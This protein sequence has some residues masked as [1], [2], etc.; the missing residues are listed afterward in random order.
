MECPTLP[1][2]NILAAHSPAAPDSAEHIESTGTDWRL[3]RA[4]MVLVFA[5]WT[6][7]ALLAA[8][9]RI[10]DP[11]TPGLQF[12]LPTGPVALAFTESYLWALLTPA[13]FWLSS[14]F[15]IDRANRV[16]RILLLIGIGLLVAVGVDL[17]LDLFRLQL[18]DVPRW[19]RGNS[20][21]WLPITRL[22]FLNDLI[23]FFAI[24]SAGFA[25]DYFLRYRARQE[26][27][28]RLQAQ[29]AQLRAQLSE[30]RLTALQMQVNPHF[31]FN[32]L[33]AV[34]TLVERD[35]RCVRRMIAR[36]SELLR[37]TLDGAAAQEVPLRQELQFLERY[38]D[39]MQVRFQ[40]RMVVETEVD[41]S[42]MDALVPNLILQPV[43]ENAIKHGVSKM[44]AE[45]RIEIAARRSGD[46]LV[47]TVLDNGPGLT[48]EPRAEGGDGLGLANT[49]ARLEQL[50]GE[51]QRLT[52]EPA[53]DGRGAMAR[54]ELPFHE[55]PA[56]SAEPH[57]ATAR[58]ESHV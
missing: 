44:S 11:R 12:G 19:R 33:H 43:V 29:T 36:L 17:M 47:L 13:I 15:S 30:A 24:L 31:L 2:R 55:A 16:G 4:E 35:P 26:E 42:A 1:K 34:S 14:R 6:F 27:A 50:Y 22:W 41:P 58:T 39:I 23:V 53:A 38:L 37:H 9:N 28:V 5:F 20:S 3:S 10:L 32:T 57:V 25:R 18:L 52:L 45:G 48:D 7:L 56:D 40:G 54:I 21:R 46:R 51:A 49:R 8:G